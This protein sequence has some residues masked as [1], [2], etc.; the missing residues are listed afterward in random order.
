MRKIDS[1]GRSREPMNFKT[2]KIARSYLTINIIEHR[3][4]GVDYIFRRISHYR[5]SAVYACD[6]AI[7]SQGALSGPKA[8]MNYSACSRFDGSH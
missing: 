3:N 6:M 2:L 5:K 7:A 4:H 8:W 1:V